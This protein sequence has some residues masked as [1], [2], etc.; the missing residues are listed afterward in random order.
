MAVRFRPNGAGGRALSPPAGVA[1]TVM[2][3]TLPG[4]AA[5]W[6]CRRGQVTAR[7]ARRSRN[8]RALE[9]RQPRA[10]G[11]KRETRRRELGGT[12][13]AD[14]CLIIARHCTWRYSLGAIR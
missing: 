11:E 7:A 14:V 12:H 8:T 1:V 3:R 9:P 13:A 5:G 10:P 6:Y 2:Y 4:A